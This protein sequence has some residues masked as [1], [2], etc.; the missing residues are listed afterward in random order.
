MDFQCPVCKKLN[1]FAKCGDKEFYIC[2]MCGHGWKLVDIEC[3]YSEDRLDEYIRDLADHMD[4][5]QLLENYI[6]LVLEYDRR[7]IERKL[8]DDLE[9][10][11]R[12]R[13]C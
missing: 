10:K 2:K 8:T 12:N 11:F 3:K 6:E 5:D 1:N 13:H 4:F 7:S 9:T